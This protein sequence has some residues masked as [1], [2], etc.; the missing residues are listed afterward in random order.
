[1]CGSWKEVAQMWQEK[2]EKLEAENK[3]LETELG[4][5]SW[6]SVA[7]RLPEIQD[8]PHACGHSDN[9]LCYNRNLKANHKAGI[10]GYYWI[11]IYYHPDN[12][13]MGDYR[14]THWMCFK[15]KI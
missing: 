8:H 5:Y 14:P 7:D 3:K 12:C 13:W 1:M 10:S 2:T 11:D 4:L 6:V 15:S 9:V